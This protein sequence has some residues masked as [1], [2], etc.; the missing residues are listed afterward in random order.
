MRYVEICTCHVLLM[1]FCA[2]VGPFGCSGTK[3]MTKNVSSGVPWPVGG[4]VGWDSVF[5]QKSK[6]KIV[7]HSIGNCLKRA[8]MTL[9]VARSEQRCRN[10]LFSVPWCL[11]RG[12]PAGGLGLSFSSEIEKKKSCSFD[13]KLS[14]TCSNDLK[15]GPK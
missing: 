14:E 10:Q 15:S 12:F 2:F 5:F 9:K 11:P 6:K 8:Q 3:T 13:R 1:S 7:A 4:G